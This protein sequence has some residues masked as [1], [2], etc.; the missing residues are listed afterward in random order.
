M[1]KNKEYFDEKIVDCITAALNSPAQDVR[2]VYD[3]FSECIEPFI[4]ELTQEIKINSKLKYN[5]D[6]RL[7][8]LLETNIIL[9]PKISKE[10]KYIVMESFDVINKRILKDLATNLSAILEY[11]KSYHI[12]EEKIRPLYDNFKEQ[13]SY[14]EEYRKSFK[15]KKIT[16]G[17]LKLLVSFKKH[18]Q[19]DKEKSDI[20]KK[21]MNQDSAAIVANIN[22]DDMTDEYSSRLFDST[23]QLPTIS[24]MNEVDGGRKRIRRRR[25]SKKSKQNRFIKKSRKI[26]KTRKSRKTRKPRKTRNNKN[27]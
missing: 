12:P 13:K 11:A 22:V 2:G 24:L 10:R 4:E 7:M 20:V 5:V 25:Q 9:N 16:P 18:Y 3:T 27:T 17:L 1:N 6:E 15:E 21:W 26:R 19:A 8:K 23:T 14:N